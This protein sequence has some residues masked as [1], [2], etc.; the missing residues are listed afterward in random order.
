MKPDRWAVTASIAWVTG[1]LTFFLFVCLFP[2]GLY[3]RGAHY[4]EV[5]SAAQGDRK[6]DLW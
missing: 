2:A 3:S 6:P 1:L 5:L 4:R